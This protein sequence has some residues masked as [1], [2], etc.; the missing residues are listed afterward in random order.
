MRT[1]SILTF[2]FVNTLINTTADAGI[3]VELDL[4]V[5]S[6]LTLTATTGFASK[7]RTGATG[8][9]VIFESPTG[10]DTDFK[11]VTPNTYGF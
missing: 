2:R 6:E 10:L 9:G 4:S 5:N 11:S 3:L 1:L 7:K 8:T